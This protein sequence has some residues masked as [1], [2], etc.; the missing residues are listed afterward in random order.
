MIIQVRCS[1]PSPVND[2]RGAWILWR[3]K[4]QEARAE[5]LVV[6][7]EPLPPSVAEIFKP[8]HEYLNSGSKEFYTVFRQCIWNFFSIY[9]GLK[10]SGMSRTVW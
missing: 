5:K 6:I 8:A 9:L 2:S 10:G 1:R 7:K 4:L 3:R